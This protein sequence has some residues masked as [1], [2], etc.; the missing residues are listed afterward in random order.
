MKFLDFL[1]RGRSQSTGQSSKP[2]FF[3][4]FRR[5]R[6][7]PKIPEDQQTN[8]EQAARD[9]EERGTAIINNFYSFLED[10]SKEATE[11]KGHESPGAGLYSGI[12]QDCQNLI[13][14]WRASVGDGVTGDARSEEHTSELQ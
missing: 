1:F 8:D 7:E 5:K 9:Y 2:G 11:I 14:K 3:G 12:A 4:L 13:E 10:R 6:K